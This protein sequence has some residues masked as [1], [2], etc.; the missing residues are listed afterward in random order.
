MANNEMSLLRAAELA[1]EIAESWIK[2]QLEG[3]TH[4]K[5]EMRR[6]QPIKRAIDRARKTQDWRQR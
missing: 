4:F 2:D 6:L 5:S 1:L 3:T